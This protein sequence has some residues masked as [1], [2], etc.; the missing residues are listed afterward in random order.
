MQLM[1]I[2]ENH[3]TKKKMKMKFILMQKQQTSFY[4]IK[5][6]QLLKLNRNNS[7]LK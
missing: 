2:K 5:K 1:T 6:Q 3:F 4:R 7:L